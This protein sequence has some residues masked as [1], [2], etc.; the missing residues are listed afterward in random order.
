LIELNSTN[1]FEPDIKV[2][3]HCYFTKWETILNFP[4][5]NNEVNQ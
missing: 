4:T 3:I 2:Q 1:V 5:S